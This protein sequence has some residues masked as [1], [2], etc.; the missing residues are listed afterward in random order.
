MVFPTKKFALAMA[1]ICAFV[2]V[3]GGSRELLDKEACHTGC[4]H[5]CINR[6]NLHFE[7][8]DSD[9]RRQCGRLRRGFK[10]QP[11]MLGMPLR[12]P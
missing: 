10:I 5:D 9:C 8:C 7:S 4:I 11:S 2:A 1:L 12:Y 3:A 6:L